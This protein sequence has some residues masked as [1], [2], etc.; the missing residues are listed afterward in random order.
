MHGDDASGASE[1]D[2]TMLTT[3]GLKELQCWYTVDVG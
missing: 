2:Y 3:V 1:K